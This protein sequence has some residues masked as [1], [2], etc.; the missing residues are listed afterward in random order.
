MGIR[1]SSD[2]FFLMSVVA[3][4]MA[5]ISWAVE[6]IWLAASQW[7]LISISVGVWGIYLRIRDIH[8]GNGKNG[9]KK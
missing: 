2:I 8:E 3:V 5:T 9:K 4:M 1:S 6:P 7:M